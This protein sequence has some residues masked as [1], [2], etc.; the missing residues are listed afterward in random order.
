MRYREQ[1]RLFQDLVK[2]RALEKGRLLGLDVGDKYVGLAVSDGQNKIASPLSVLV[3]TKTNV[4]LMV[5]DFQCLISKL[6][7]VGFIVGYPFDKQRHCH[8]QAIQVKV[9]VDNLRKTGKLEGIQYTYWN[10]CYT[11]KNAE[12]LLNPLNLHPVEAKTII[13]KYAAAGILQMNIRCIPIWCSNCDILSLIASEGYVITFGDKDTL[14]STGA[15]RIKIIARFL[16]DNTT[17][18][19]YVEYLCT[20]SDNYSALVVDYLTRIP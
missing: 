16:H 19:H 8:N 9:F 14:K 18:S 3:R 17:T 7:L 11:S 15:S 13:D 4:D 1:L 2:A 10:E 6:S 20:R 12:L 5:S